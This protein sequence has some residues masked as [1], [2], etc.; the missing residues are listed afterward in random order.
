MQVPRT[1]PEEIEYMD[2]D[3]QLIKLA[4]L[5]FS[6]GIY[7]WYRSDKWRVY[8]QTASNCWAEGRT[9]RLAMRNAIAQYNTIQN[10]LVAASEK[11]QT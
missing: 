3:S 11:T 10:L 8:I 6:P 4:E 9:P 7:L 2:F 5:G 1:I